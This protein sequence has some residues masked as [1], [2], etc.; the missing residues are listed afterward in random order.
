MPVGSE[1]ERPG[2]ASGAPAQSEDRRAGGG[3]RG[4]SSP[5]ARIRGALCSCSP[6]ARWESSR[7][8][9]VPASCNGQSLWARKV[10]LEDTLAAGASSQPRG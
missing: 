9:G 10:S 5:Q 6:V 7:P 2:P 8:G 1:A 3:F 4:A